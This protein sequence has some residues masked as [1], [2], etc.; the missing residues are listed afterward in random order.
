MLTS[1]VKVTVIVGVNKSTSNVCEV[2]L[3]AYL[4]LSEVNS[5]TISFSPALIRA[6]GIVNLATPS[7]NT[8]VSTTSP[9]T[10]NLTLPVPF[11]SPNLTVTL[12]STSLNNIASPTSIVT[13][14]V[15]LAN[16]VNANS[17]TFVSATVKLINSSPEAD[18]L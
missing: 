16:T 12:A 18:A 15:D 13:T 9:L 3:S 14:G 8:T 2:V 17:H 4:T 6:L 11:S 5:E 7:S 1:S 10:T